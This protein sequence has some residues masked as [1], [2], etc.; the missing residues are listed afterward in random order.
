M[1]TGWDM[2]ASGA[3]GVKVTVIAERPFRRFL[4]TKNQ[5]TK[6]TR[7]TKRAMTGTVLESPWTIPA[8]GRRDAPDRSEESKTP[9]RSSMYSTVTIHPM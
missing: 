5:K 7:P 8:R 4:T 9:N 1:T 3:H 2:R 6:A